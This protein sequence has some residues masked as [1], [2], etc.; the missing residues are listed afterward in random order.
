MPRLNQRLKCEQKCGLLYV[1]GHPGQGKTALVNQV[2][3]EYFG[4][5]GQLIGGTDERLYIL[6]YNGMR[7]GTPKQFSQ[8]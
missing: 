6:K 2:L 7:F 4:D 5:H 8:T 1:C 3:F